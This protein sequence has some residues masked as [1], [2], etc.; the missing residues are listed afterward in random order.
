MPWGQTR[1]FVKVFI[2]T[3]RQFT[4]TQSTS[5]TAFNITTSN[6]QL[7]L[8]SGRWWV[9]VLCRDW[10]LRGGGASKIISADKW[11]EWGTGAGTCAQSWVL[12]IKCYQW[13]RNYILTYFPVMWRSKKDQFSFIARGCDH[14][15]S[16]EKSRNVIIARNRGEER[17][18][19]GTRYLESHHN[20]GFS[21]MN[22]E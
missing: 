2:F 8:V 1:Q 13:I 10:T 18:D 6:I 3:N 5:R 11:L 9:Y 7:D 16:G 20:F 19:I 14:D 21:A 17:K 15:T 4:R 22:L 12:T